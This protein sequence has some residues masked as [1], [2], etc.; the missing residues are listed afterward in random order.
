MWIILEQSTDDI[1]LILETNVVSLT[2]FTREVIQDMKSRG[3]KDGHIFNINRFN[4]LKLQFSIFFYSFLMFCSICGQY[5]TIHPYGYIYTASKHAVTVINEG[6]RRELRDMQTKTKVTVSFFFTIL[7]IFLF[8]PV[9]QSI[10]PG[11]VRTE[12]SVAGGI[13]KDVADKKYS[14][15]PVLEPE[16]VA[17][18]V[19]YALGTPP[20][21]QVK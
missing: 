4:H 14:E 1:R 16:D 21:V 20:H 10:S 18:A 11:L 9:S 17:G 6:L 15:N 12:I 8:W 19:L 2:V 7:H 13:P 3:V 5:I